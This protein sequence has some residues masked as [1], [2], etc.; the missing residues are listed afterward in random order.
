MVTDFHKQLHD[1]QPPKD[2]DI[3]L[4]GYV[5][6]KCSNQER[7]DMIQVHRFFGLHCY[8]INRRFVKKF[9]DSEHSKTIGKQI[10]SVLSDMIA[11]GTIKVYAARKKMA[12]QNNRHGTTIQM[13]IKPT[14]GIDVWATE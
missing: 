3:L 8:M 6:N 4:F 12:W 7:G 13:P 14:P 11:E 5:C 2:W 9:F 1:I 10:D